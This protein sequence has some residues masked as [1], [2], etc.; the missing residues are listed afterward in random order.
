MPQ[1][2]VELSGVD[3]RFRDGTVALRDLTLT[4]ATGEFVAVVGPSG[5]GKT[6]LLRIVAG[7]LEP[8]GGRLGRQTDDIGYVF[9]EPTLLPWRTVRRNV[10]LFCELRGVPRDERR[11]RADEALDQ[12]GL[13]EFARSRPHTLSGGMKMRVALARTLSLRPKLCLFDEPFGSL[14]ELT[15]ER[16]GEE[17]QALFAAEGFGALFVT[18]SVA[19]AVY[20]ADRVVVLSPRPGRIAGEVEV[21]QPMPRP[22]EARFGEELTRVGAKVSTLLRDGLLREGLSRDGAA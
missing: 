18:H 17:L 5:C 11:T 22:P 9:Q 19:E 12:V 2:L 8:T 20:V 1:P 3:L 14:D 21:G 10:E 7:L 16:L 15:R 13:T 4:V 6:S